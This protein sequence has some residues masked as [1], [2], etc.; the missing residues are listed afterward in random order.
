[1]SEAVKVRNWNVD[2]AASRDW[3]KLLVRLREQ[4]MTTGQ[5]YG[6]FVTIDDRVVFIGGPGDG[7]GSTTARAG[8]NG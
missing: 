6:R 2:D 5:K 8:R 4:G 1:M 3:L 7:A